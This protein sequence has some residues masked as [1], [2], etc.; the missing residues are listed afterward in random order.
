[1]ASDEIDKLRRGVVEG[2]PMIEIAVPSEDDSSV[3]SA[4]P[5][6]G[7]D[8]AVQHR[9]QVKGRTA[10]NFEHVGCRGLLLQRLAQLAP[11]PR[12]LCFLPGRS[13]TAAA[14]DLRRIGAL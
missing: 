2:D 12:N 10:N 8:K 4:E 3:C 11:E 14:H 6:L 5:R 9:L 13:G 7:L 1:M